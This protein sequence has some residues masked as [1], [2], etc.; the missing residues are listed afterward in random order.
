M[1]QST[2]SIKTVAPETTEGVTEKLVTNQL[3]TTGWVEH[4]Y[5]AKPTQAGHKRVFINMQAKSKDGLYGATKQMSISNNG[6]ARCDQFL[7]LFEAGH[8]L[9]R[10][11][12]FEQTWHA[13]SG[14]RCSTWI[15][16]DVMPMGNPDNKADQADDC[17][18]TPE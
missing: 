11:V 8:R 18:E 1:T 15:V 10:F 5:K 14:K 16:T 17:D 7:E 9:F 12:C 6:V 2:K 13:K 3:I 4:E